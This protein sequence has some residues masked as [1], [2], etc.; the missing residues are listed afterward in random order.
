MTLPCSVSVVRDSREAGVSVRPDIHLTLDE[1][2][3]SGLKLGEVLVG[4]G[5]EVE[6][7]EP[8]GVTD[9]VWDK[10]TSSTRHTAVLITDNLALVVALDGLVHT[11][12]VAGVSGWE[13]ELRT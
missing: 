8:V 7:G 2:L 5:L 9:N 11:E 4:V 12:R 10:H 13:G 6:D 3:D 1:D